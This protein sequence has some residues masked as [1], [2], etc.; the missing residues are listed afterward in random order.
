MLNGIKTTME[1]PSEENQ[2][3]RLD[4]RGTNESS[5]RASSLLFTTVFTGA[6]TY[7]SLLAFTLHNSWGDFAQQGLCSSLF[8]HR[9]QVMIFQCLILPRVASVMLLVCFSLLLL[10][11]IYFIEVSGIFS[12]DVPPAAEGKL[13]CR[14]S[15]SRYCHF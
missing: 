15:S 10:L 9:T 8:H 2:D 6:L 13:C 11:M 3:Q 4:K 7:S 1:T 12:A 14:W 5:Q